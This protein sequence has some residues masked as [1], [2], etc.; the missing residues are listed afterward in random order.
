[1]RK[2][3]NDL[4]KGLK[5]IL[6]KLKIVPVVDYDQPDRIRTGS[7]AL[8]YI[9]G[10]GLPRGRFVELSG[11]EAYGKTTLAAAISAYVLASDPQAVVAYY[12]AEHTYDPLWAASKTVD[13]SRF[14][15]TQPETMEEGFNQIRRLIINDVCDL[16]VFDSLAGARIQEEADK[17]IGERSMRRAS[18]VQH[19]MVSTIPDLSKSRCCILIINQLRD[20]I[21]VVYGDPTVTPGGKMKNHAFSIRVR[22]NKPT[23]FP[24]KDNPIGYNFK[25]KTFKN[26]TH[27]PFKDA[28]VCF[29]FNEP[30]GFDIVR[31]VV[32]IGKKTG[33]FRKENGEMIETSRGTWHL[34][35][36]KIGTGANGVRLALWQDDDLRD[37]ILELFYAMI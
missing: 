32:D 34:E 8:D 5:K 26:K 4:D 16:I 15:L 19:F 14:I 27:T 24:D 13:A 6:D 30:V 18:I 23:L 3:M 36:R 29:R 33:L 22:M 10:G 37:E 2:K 28:E 25:V 21:G 9:L 31:E 20:L 12:D 11:L 1:M 35:G 17:D 7:A